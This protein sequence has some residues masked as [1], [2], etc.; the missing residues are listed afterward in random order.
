MIR[1]PLSSEQA[2]REPGLRRE[3]LEGKERG[4][5]PVP[6]N[7]ADLA[8]PFPASRTK[9]RQS[10]R[11]RTVTA[12]R[13]QR[14]P[15]NSS[16]CVNAEEVPLVRRFRNTRR[17]REKP[18]PDSGC[19][20]GRGNPKAL[21]SRRGGLGGCAIEWGGGWQTGTRK[22][23]SGGPSQRKGNSKAI[24]RKKSMTRASGE[25]RE[26]RDH[27][28]EESEEGIQDSSR[29]QKAARTP[30][31][32]WPRKSGW[33]TTSRSNTSKSDSRPP[34]F[35][36]LT[37]NPRGAPPRAE[38]TRADPPPQKA[39]QESPISTKAGLH[40]TRKA[41]DPPKARGCPRGPRA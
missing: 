41:S 38:E 12:T 26:P 8:T 33:A 36:P 34:S 40:P 28:V 17:E 37:R 25:S 14:L 6:V 10:P 22:E 20:G 4:T 23:A 31:K 2:R 7:P 29:R 13:R 3:C 9:T 5:R 30:T 11:L 18:R 1:L 16:S 32:E 15:L 21:R 24:E 35:P 39:R 27:P 19:E